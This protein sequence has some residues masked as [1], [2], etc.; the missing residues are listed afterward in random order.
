MKMRCVKDF[1]NGEKR[2]VFTTKFMKNLIHSYCSNQFSIP[3]FYYTQRIQIVIYSFR[4]R[5]SFEDL[6]LNSWKRDIK[7]IGSNNFHLVVRTWPILHMDVREQN[8][9]FARIKWNTL[10]LCK[11]D[12]P[13]VYNSNSSNTE[14]TRNQNI[15]KTG[16]KKV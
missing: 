1:S 7:T 11:C 12:V 10:H 5:T 2:H 13:N 3:I 14:M 4:M 9:S 8:Y 15:K 16:R 6:N